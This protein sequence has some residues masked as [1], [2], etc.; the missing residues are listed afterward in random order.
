MISEVDFKDRVLNVVTES[1]MHDVCSESLLELLKLNVDVYNNSR[2]EF[3]A[4]K[5]IIKKAIM[6]GYCKTVEFF[7]G[8][9][10]REWEAEKALPLKN[11]RLDLKN[12]STVRRAIEAKCKQIM[13]YVDRFFPAEETNEIESA[14]ATDNEDNVDN[15]TSGDTNSSITDVIIDIDLNGVASIDEDKIVTVDR[16]TGRK[17]YLIHFNFDLR[18]PT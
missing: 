5:V 18:K 3:I 17:R 10:M 7:D 1:N 2:E 12:I 16:S 8:T 11:R 6:R 4:D 13:Y 14:A 9:S 15:V